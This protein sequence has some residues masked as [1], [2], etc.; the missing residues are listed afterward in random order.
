MS[1]SALGAGGFPLERVF[2]AVAIVSDA[3][4]FKGLTEAMWRER[5]LK[6][7]PVVVMSKGK[8]AAQ[9]KRGSVLSAALFV[10]KFTL[11]LICRYRR[12]PRE[13]PRLKALWRR[14]PI[15]RFIAFEILT[16]GSLSFEYFFRSATFAFVHATRFVLR[17]VFLAI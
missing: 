3:G 17:L 7:D 16:T 12:W 2:V 15:V 1:A 5:H 13:M 8:R 14:A 10:C 4:Q 9:A 6:L 11:C